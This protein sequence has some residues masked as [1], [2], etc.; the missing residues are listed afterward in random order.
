[1]LVISTGVTQRL[2]AP[3][4]APV[5]RRG[6]D[7]PA[8]G[9]R[10]AGGRALGDRD[11]GRR[12]RGQHRGQPGHDLAGQAGRP[13]LPGRAGPAAAPPPGVE[14]G[15]GAPEPSGVTA[16]P[17]PPGSRAGRLRLRRDHR[18]TGRV[19]HRAAADVRRRRGLGDRPGAPEHRL[20]AGR[21]ARRR[22]LRPRRPRPAGA[23]PDR[24]LRHRRRR[25]HRP[26]AL[27]R[28][29]PRR[30]TA[31]PQHP[32]RPRRASRCAT[33]VR[34]S[35]AGARSSAFQPNGLEVFAPTG[36]AFRFPAWS[37]RSVLQPG[38]VRWGIYRG[39]RRS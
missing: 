28:A 23:R 36:R 39:V 15:R 30:P 4:R 2:L 10:A 5:D 34:R 8:A 6:R 33:T 26:A 35:G 7:R 19:E 3:A 1:M 27:V 11:R 24:G 29:Q 13:L 21:P 14:P 20:A 37:I 12:R 9:P 16:A 25:G 32:R 22:R 38:I 31:R 18:R 17:G